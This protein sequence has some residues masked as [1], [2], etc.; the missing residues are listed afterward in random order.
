MKK[1]F[2]IVPL[3]LAMTACSSIKYNTGVE[4]SA[5][6]FGSSEGR[7]VGYPDWYTAGAK[8]DDTALYSVATEHSKNFQFAVDK[9]MMS[10]K[11]ELASNFSSHINAMLKDFTAEIGEDNTVVNEINRT[12]KMIVTRVNLIGVQRTNFKVV[13]E[14]DG[15]R[16]FVRLKYS[17]DDTNKI[18]VNEIKKNRKLASKLEASKSFKEMEESVEKVERSASNS[19][20]EVNPVQ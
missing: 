16:A 5:P 17:I 3:V 1:T 7:E 18:M 19:N 20:I 14:N 12:T 13:H 8:S 9:A 6:S 2:V 11:R 10:G 4:F 15:Y